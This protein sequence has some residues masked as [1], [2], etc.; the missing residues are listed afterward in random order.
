MLGACA[1]GLLPSGKQRGE[2]IVAV[3]PVV[4]CKFCLSTKSWKPHCLV[5]ETRVA[6]VPFRAICF[7][8]SGIKVWL[9]IHAHC[10]LALPH[11][12]LLL[13]AFFSPFFEGLYSTL[14]GAPGFGG[15]NILTK[16]CPGCDA[17]IK[18]QRGDSA[19]S[20]HVSVFPAAVGNKQ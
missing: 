18:Q 16:L 1:G 14:T 10:L 19:L 20:V 13:T 8:F 12:A 17:N 7:P 11:L 5:D 3:T 4:L 9:S 15:T 6:E 2:K